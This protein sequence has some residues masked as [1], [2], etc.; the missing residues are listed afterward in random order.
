[1]VSDPLLNLRN[2]SG[3]ARENLVNLS[4]KGSP[5]I[6]NLVQAANPF[7][8]EVL[9]GRYSQAQQP[10]PKANQGQLA[11]AA[12]ATASQ[13]P[14]K[15]GLNPDQVYVPPTKATSV[16]KAKEEVEKVTEEPTTEKIDQPTV[17]TQSTIPKSNKPNLDVE[18]S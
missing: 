10:D 11:E 3:Q 15:Q 17:V 14:T 12:S 9:F 8:K 18:I 7:S 1:M 6:T 5:L 2:L 4:G 13:T 16:F